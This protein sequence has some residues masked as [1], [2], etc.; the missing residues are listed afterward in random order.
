MNL[1]TNALDCKIHRIFNPHT[2]F[3]I[4]SGLP[5]AICKATAKRISVG[6]NLGIKSYPD[7]AY[8]GYYGVLDYLDGKGQVVTSVPNFIFFT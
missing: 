3:Q 2:V 8:F 7:S 6:R 5:G 4:L 1:N